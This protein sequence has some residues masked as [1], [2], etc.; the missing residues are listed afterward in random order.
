MSF[1][2]HSLDWAGLP[3]VFR[4][5]HIEAGSLRDFLVST[6]LKFGSNA[7]HQLA[8]KTLRNAVCLRCASIHRGLHISIGLSS[9]WA[10]HKSLCKQSLQSLGDFVRGT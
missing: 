1:L 3:P 7:L 8:L 4:T 9:A 6:V 2:G 5:S 10:G